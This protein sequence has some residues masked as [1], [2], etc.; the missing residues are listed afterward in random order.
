MK[1]CIYC[2]YSFDVPH[3]L[4]TSKILS[5]LF[6]FLFI[7]LL[8]S[9]LIIILSPTFPLPFTLSF[10]LLYNLISLLFSL[11]LP[12]FLAFRILSSYYKFTILS[13]ILYIFSHRQNVIFSLSKLFFIF[14]WNVLFFLHL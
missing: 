12:L 14:W 8:I 2:C 13:L 4:P 10:P 9:Q 1:H 6:N 3:H 11:Y 5:L 7:Y